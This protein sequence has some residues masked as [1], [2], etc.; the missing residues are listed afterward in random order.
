MDQRTDLDEDKKAALNLGAR[1]LHETYFGK[2]TWQA[3]GA[4]ARQHARRSL[5][6]ALSELARQGYVLVKHD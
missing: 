6:K 1:A 5:Q 2:G 3:Y 4:E